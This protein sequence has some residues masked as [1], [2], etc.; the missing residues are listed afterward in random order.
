MHHRCIALRIFLAISKIA[1]AN[2]MSKY[3]YVNYYFKKFTLTER[4]HMTASTVTQFKNSLNPD[5]YFHHG[6]SMV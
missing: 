6:I 3:M 1:N 4:A 5:I 2:G